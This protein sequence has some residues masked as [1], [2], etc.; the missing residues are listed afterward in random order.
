MPQ[1][2]KVHAIFKIQGERLGLWIEQVFGSPSYRQS[3]RHGSEEMNAEQ[4]KMIIKNNKQPEID[5]DG[6]YNLFLNNDVQ[7]AKG[8]LEAL[9]GPEVK[10]LVKTLEFI[11]SQTKEEGTEMHCYWTLSKYHEATKP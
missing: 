5:Q 4:A 6:N 7:R 9:E 11:A 2:I 1:K 3:H 8:Y 10:A